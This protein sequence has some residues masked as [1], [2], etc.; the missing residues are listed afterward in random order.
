MA[1][2]I[3]RT[4]GLCGGDTQISDDDYQQLLDDHAFVVECALAQRPPFFTQHQS[5]FE[6]LEA[7]AVVYTG[8][9]TPLVE[10]VDYTIDLQRGIVT[11]PQANYQVI[12]IQGMAYDINAAAADGW[13]RIAARHVGA[14]DLSADGSS[15][16]RSQAHDQA[17]LQAATYRAKAW[18]VTT[19]VDRADTPGQ[20][21]AEHLLQSFRQTFR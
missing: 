11:T 7:G 3:A 5:P 4:K 18:A 13:E 2:L 19:T 21:H 10:G 6:N 14:F 20:T 16:R 9:N 17:L 15:L 1:A 8:Y 12:S